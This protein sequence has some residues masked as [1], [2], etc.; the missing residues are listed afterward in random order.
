MPRCR[1]PGFRKADA[2]GVQRER[3]LL[4]REV[5]E[6]HLLFHDRQGLPAN[7]ERETSG[8]VHDGERSETGGVELRRDVSQ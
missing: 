1:L 3:K 6:G 2:T 7:H 5:A 8:A 4:E